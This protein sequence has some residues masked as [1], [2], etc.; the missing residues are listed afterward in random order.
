MVYHVGGATLSQGNPKKTYLNF[1]N[2]LWMLVK[3]L[4]K[5]K[6]FQVLFIRLILDGLAGI[7]FLFKGK[8]KNLFAVLESHFS[9]YKM[10]LTNYKKRDTKQKGN[11]FNQ[12]SIVYQYFINNGKVFGN[13][14]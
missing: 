5:N 4:P 9:F 6:L 7:Q 3:N 1:R 8:L 11:Y 2:S 14:K 13:L 12:K 10:F